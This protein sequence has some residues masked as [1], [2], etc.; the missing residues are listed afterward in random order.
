V[1]LFAVF[2]AVVARGRRRFAV[3]H[4]AF[5][6]HVLA[7]VFCFIPIGAYLIQWPLVLYLRRIHY[8]QGVLGYDGP[9]SLALALCLA[10]YFGLAARRAY[11]MTWVRAVA[12]GPLLAMSFYVCLQLYRALLFWVT[13]WSV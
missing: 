10:T 11:S 2:A 5:S 4:L 6:L 13:L 8:A 9:V 3:Q 7:W 1:P 12:T